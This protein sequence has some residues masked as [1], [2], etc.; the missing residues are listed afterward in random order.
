[1]TSSEFKNLFLPLQRKLY[2]EAYK[3]LCDSFEA[4]DAV[5]NL[6]LRLWEKRNGLGTLVAPEA[7]C[8]KVLRNICIDRLRQKRDMDDTG[9]VFDE[10]PIDAPPDIER[11]ETENCLRHFLASL[12]ELHSRVVEMKMNGLD[13]DE[14]EKI[15]GLSAVNV[16]VI[17]SRVRKKLREYYNK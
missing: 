11:V 9:T 2:R 10:I 13:Y 12:P 17:G 5:Q 16:R 8:I 3:M 15:T 1:M 7:Y 14:I 4:E 6:Y